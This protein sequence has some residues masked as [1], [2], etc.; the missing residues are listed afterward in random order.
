MKGTQVQ[1]LAQEESTCLGATKAVSG[2]Y[3]SPCAATTEA[4]APGA[5]AVKQEKPSKLEAH[6]P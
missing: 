2:N 1:S 3:L 4:G 5:C 6:T